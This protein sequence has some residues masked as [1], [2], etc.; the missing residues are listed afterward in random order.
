[1]SQA[2]VKLQEILNKTVDTKN[3]FGISASVEKGDHSFSFSGAAGNLK[4]ESQFFIASTTKLYITAI[5]MKLRE[6]GKLK[7]DDAIS[8]YFDASILD[9]LFVYKGRDYGRAISIRQLLAH[10]SG[11]PDYFQQKRASGKSLQDE[12]TSGKDQAWSFEQVIDDVKTMKPPFKP[13]QKGRALYSDTNYQLLGK[14][15]ETV[16]GSELAASLNAYIVNPLNLKQTYL[17]TDSQDSLP[18]TIHFKDKPLPIPLAMTSF[19]ADGGIVSTSAELMT[20]IKAFFRGELFPVGYFSEMKH[21]KRIFFPLEYGVGLARFKLPRL[22]S[23]FKPLPEL[24]GHSGLSGAYA[25]Y[26]AEK[27]IFLTGTVNQIHKPGS[28]FRLMLKLLNQLS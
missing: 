12:L 2:R 25:F 27:D 20:F 16:T 7:L 1:M 9:G 11:L 10:T 13:G 26:S 3:V 18:A 8:G 24:I 4:T 22:F 15:I 17:Y 21:W 14:L 5:I 23:P 6:Q 19:A 28:S